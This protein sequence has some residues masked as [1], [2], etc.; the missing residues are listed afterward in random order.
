MDHFL[1]HGCQD[2]EYDQTIGIASGSPRSRVLRRT[3]DAPRPALNPQQRPAYASHPTH[4]SLRRMQSR[5]MMFTREPVTA[6]SS[7]QSLGNPVRRS[8]SGMKNLLPLKLLSPTASELGI[9][10]SSAPSHR[11]TFGMRLSLKVEER[12]S[13]MNEH[14]DSQRARPAQRPRRYRD[15]PIFAEPGTPLPSPAYFTNDNVCL[16]CP[17]SGSICDETCI[18]N[19]YDKE[20]KSRH[21]Q[22][23]GDLQVRT[24]QCPFIR[25]TL[26]NITLGNDRKYL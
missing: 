13:S 18:I 23:L 17:P 7:E 16:R 3:Y 9:W 24:V 6:Q 15:T 4:I 25:W 5:T 19:D 12:R 8:V 20:K 26:S 10:P 22:E 2:V 11:T 1:G 21:E 14:T